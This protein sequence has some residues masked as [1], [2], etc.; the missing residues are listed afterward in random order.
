[1]I[2]G[3]FALALFDHPEGLGDIRG[4]RR[5]QPDGGQGG[6]RELVRGLVIV[7]DQHILTGQVQVF[8]LMHRFFHVQRNMKMAALSLLALHGDR[9]AHCVHNILGDGHAHS[10]PG[11]FIHTGAVFSREGVEYPALELLGHPD[12]VVLDMQVGADVIIALRRGLLI[13]LD[14]NHAAFRGEFDRVPEDVQKD[15]A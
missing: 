5:V 8:L 4:G 2:G 9:A 3:V 6:H 12:A 7:Y 10:G 13:Q 14:L 11:N 1:M 15:L